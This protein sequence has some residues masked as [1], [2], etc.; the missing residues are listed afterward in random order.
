MLVMKFSAWARDI[1]KGAAVCLMAGLSG[2]R[3]SADWHTVM[4]VIA[5]TAGTAE[6]SEPVSSFQAAEMKTTWREG[7]GE[8]R[9]TRDEGRGRPGVPELKVYKQ[10]EWNDTNTSSNYCGRWWHFDKSEQ[11]CSAVNGRLFH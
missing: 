11:R 5:A 4:S 10:H 8:G 7:Q 6:D 1:I 9:G 2:S 3:D